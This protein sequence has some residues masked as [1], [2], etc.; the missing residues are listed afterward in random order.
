MHLAK[1]YC[2]MHPVVVGKLISNGLMSNKTIHHVD[3]YVGEKLRKRRLLLKVSQE[4]LAECVDLTFQQIQKYEKGLNRISCSKLYEF[5][6]FLK[7]DIEYF[8]QGL[9]G[10]CPV[11]VVGGADALCDSATAEYVAPGPQS[12]SSEVS[13]LSNDIDTL[14][15]AFSKIKNR[16]VRDHVLSLVQS[17]NRKTN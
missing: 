2:I 14:I 8:F 10:A 3:K 16:E 9:S 5:A 1:C 17:L 6:H 13:K 4:Q 12:G 7:T 15:T 11:T